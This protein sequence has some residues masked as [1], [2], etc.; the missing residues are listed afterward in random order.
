M[1]WNKEAEWVKVSSISICQEPEI[2]LGKGWGAYQLMVLLLSPW[3]AYAVLARLLDRVPGCVLL[4]LESLNRSCSLDRFTNFS[5]SYRARL[6]DLYTITM[7]VIDFV[8]P[9]L[10]HVLFFK[11]KC[12]LVCF[13]KYRTLAILAKIEFESFWFNHISS[14]RSSIG[15]LE[16]FWS[17]TWISWS[18]LWLSCEIW[19]MI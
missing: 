9:L 7:R 3:L 4:R 18:Y 17:R 8:L 10:R 5:H 11:L 16:F 13:F 2:Y 6:V 19:V 14:S 1:I 15:F 12:I